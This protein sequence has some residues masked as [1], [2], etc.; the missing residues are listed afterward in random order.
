MRRLPEFLCLM[1]MLAQSATAGRGFVLCT[2]PGGAVKLEV[3]AGDP[4]AS[5]TAPGG[6]DGSGTELQDG[7]R[8]PCIDVSLDRWTDRGRIERVAS[9]A[10][11]PERAPACEIPH[12]AP[13][14]DAALCLAAGRH[15][16][17]VPDTA[18]GLVG[19]I[20]LRV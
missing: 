10:Q 8:C 17:P 12:P 4:C 15:P 18:R 16:A 7:P 14:P 20:V 2:E 9:G 5:C 6:A 19:T 1:L 3:A 11:P 13:L